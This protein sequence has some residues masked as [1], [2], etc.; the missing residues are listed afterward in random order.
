MYINFRPITDLPTGQVVA[1]P[2]PGETS[3]SGMQSTMGVKVRYFTFSFKGPG[4]SMNR[5]GP[6]ADGDLML[7]PCDDVLCRTTLFRLR[8][9]NLKDSSCRFVKLFRIRLSL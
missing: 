4:C 3:T 8:S 7:H 6:V 2:A 9:N 1:T 5:L